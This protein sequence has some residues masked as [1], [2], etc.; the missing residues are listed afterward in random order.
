MDVRDGLVRFEAC[1]FGWI[2]CWFGECES[3]GGS[4]GVGIKRAFSRNAVF[5][6]T[7]MSGS[8]WDAYQLRD[9]SNRRSHTL[10]CITQFYPPVNF[11]S[12]ENFYSGRIMFQEPGKRV[13]GLGARLWSG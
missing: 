1:E 11:G 8:R 6:R 13:D 12:T 5:R 9:G 7:V 4:E 3:D 10:Q 2:G